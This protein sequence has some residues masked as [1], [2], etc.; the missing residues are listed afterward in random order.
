M[1]NLTFKFIEIKRKNGIDYLYL[2]LRVPA[3]L[4][5]FVLNC[6]M[7]FQRILLLKTGYNLDK[8]DNRKN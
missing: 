3:S 7:L 5:L 4:V 6:H 2:F 1:L 8:L